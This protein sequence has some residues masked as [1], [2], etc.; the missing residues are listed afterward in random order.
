MPGHVEPVRVYG[1]VFAALLGLTAVTT[2]VAFVDLGRWND[3]VMLAIA[4]TKATLVV[5]VFMHL[6]HET[7]LTQLA[8]AGAVGGFLLLVALTL[9]DELT[10]PHLAGLDDRPPAPAAPAPGAR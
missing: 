2:A 10:R 8:L 5:L 1:G 9:A 7:R 6:R 3:V 4:V